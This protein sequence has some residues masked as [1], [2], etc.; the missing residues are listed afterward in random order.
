ML[1]EVGS[2]VYIQSYKHNGSLHRTWCKGFV[3]ESDEDRYVAVTNKA[4]VIEGDGRTLMLWKDP[5]VPKVGE[6]YYEPMIVQYKPIKKECKGYKD[7]K[8]K[9]VFKTEKE[10][11]SGMTVSVM[12]PTACWT[13][14]I[15]GPTPIRAG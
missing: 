12:F 11:Y 5:W 14:G 15:A 10:W 2:S 3:L 4:W 1:P 6:T 9:R 8:G 7:F 13:V